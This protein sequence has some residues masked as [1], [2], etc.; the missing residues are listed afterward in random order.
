MPANQ[1]NVRFRNLTCPTQPTQ[2]N[3]RQRSKYEFFFDRDQTWTKPQI[4]SEFWDETED[5]RGAFSHHGHGKLAEPL[6]SPS[7]QPSVLTSQGEKSINH[8]VVHTDKGYFSPEWPFRSDE[9][10]FLFRHFQKAVLPWFDASDRNQC[11]KRY[12][13]HEINHSPVLLYACCAL[14]AKHLSHTAA[15]SDLTH[16][17]YHEKCLSLLLPLLER[18]GISNDLTVLTTTCV[19]RA[20]EEIDSPSPHEDAQRHFLGISLLLTGPN[21]DLSS[22]SSSVRHTMVWCHLRQEIY[23][24]FA[25]QQPMRINFNDLLFEPESAC[26]DDIAWANRMVWHGTEAM[27]WAFNGHRR[28][29]ED[30]DR[31]WMLM[32]TWENKWP[33]SFMPTFR[34]KADPAANRPWPEVWFAGNEHANCSM[35]AILAKIVLMTHDPRRP[36]LGRRAKEATAKIKSGLQEL[37]GELCGIALS[38][39]HDPAWNGACVAITVC[40]SDWITDPKELSRDC[41]A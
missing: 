10:A 3:K 12:V 13:Q 9:E 6:P 19:L 21:I 22:N 8:S 20:Y 27:R 16:L 33:R 1:F 4:D 24:S 34:R 17:L 7:A 36:Q 15:Y 35:E 29:L 37:I 2:P 30:W 18:E 5:V 25:L 26:Q 39:D 40:G 31:L 32:S 41:R 38:N 11:F 28:E 23:V 14:A